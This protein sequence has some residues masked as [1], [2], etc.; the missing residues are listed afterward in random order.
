MLERVSEEMSRVSRDEKGDERSVVVTHFAHELRPV[1]LRNLFW[2][3]HK[4]VVEVERGLVVFVEGKW[5]RGSRIS[6]KMLN[7]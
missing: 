3:S 7:L 4:L 6:Q 2:R 5:S 1:A